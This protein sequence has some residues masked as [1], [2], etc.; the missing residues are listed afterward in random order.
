MYKA[1]AAECLF[2]QVELKYIRALSDVG[3]TVKSSP[4]DLK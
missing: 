1:H 4:I 3:M 2:I